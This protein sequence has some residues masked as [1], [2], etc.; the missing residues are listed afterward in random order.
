MKFIFSVAQAMLALAITVFISAPPA[1]A[2]TLDSSGTNDEYV[3]VANYAFSYTSVP[4]ALEGSCYIANEENNSS[5]VP[6]PGTCDTSTTSSCWADTCTNCAN[7]D[8]V[9]ADAYISMTSM[10]K[11]LLQYYADN[12]KDETQ[13]YCNFS[14]GPWNFSVNFGYRDTGVDFTLSLYAE[15]D[16]QNIVNNSDGWITSGTC[17]PA[18][19]SAPAGVIPQQFDANTDP[20]SQYNLICNEDFLISLAAD[21]DTSNAAMI[22]VV[23]NVNG[24]ATGAQELSNETTVTVNQA[25]AQGSSEVGLR[26]LDGRSSD[27]ESESLSSETTLRRFS[28]RT[29]TAGRWLITSDGDGQEFRG[30][31]VSGSEPS[32]TERVACQLIGH[33]GNPEIIKRN[34]EYQCDLSSLDGVSTRSDVISMPATVLR[35]RNR[36]GGLPE[37]RRTD[38]DVVSHAN[39]AI[40]A[41]ARGAR[42]GAADATKNLVWHGQTGQSRVVMVKDDLSGDIEIVTHSPKALSPIFMSC[43]AEPQV[44]AL[45]PEYLCKANLRCTGSPCP[46]ASWSARS[47]LT[48]PTAL[49]KNR[50]CQPDSGVPAQDPVLK[51]SDSVARGRSGQLIFQAGMVLPAGSAIRPDQN[52]FRLLVEDA[53]GHTVVDFDVPG[54]TPD[55]PQQG[56]WRVT[57]DLTKFTYNSSDDGGPGITI[58]QKEGGSNSWLVAATGS[59]DRLDDGDL[60]PPLAA[61]FTLNPSDENSALCATTYGGIKEPAV[62]TRSISRD[63]VLLQWTQ[64]EMEGHTFAGYTVTWGLEGSSIPAGTMFISDINTFSTVITDLDC[65]ANCSFRVSADSISLSALAPPASRIPAVGVQGLIILILLMLGIGAAGIRR[66]S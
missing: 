23:N 55:Q 37:F 52:G 64:P 47:K 45:N 34:Y 50:P 57:Q 46:D 40:K 27:F 12:H 26:Q 29:D 61:S 60:K 25:S 18:N 8:D 65:G 43:A 9:F 22:S 1:R 32:E 19:P 31:L 28:N 49:F 21:P 63:T 16:S 54:N 42:V 10:R 15:G 3:G 35:V 6:I 53:E 13:G 30:V 14:I 17:P 48:L 5:W 33:D 59:T 11:G 66:F 38:A 36:A 20:A 58:E 56:S 7:S 51:L 2:V 4:Y 24:L 44:D 62:T 39:V 41:F